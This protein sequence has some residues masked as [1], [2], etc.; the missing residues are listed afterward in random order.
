LHAILL[1]AGDE[2]LRYDI[3]RMI[4]SAPSRDDRDALIEALNDRNPHVAR[5]AARA[6]VR[7][8]DR[9]VA[10]ILRSKALDATDRK[11]AEEFN[12]AA[13]RLGG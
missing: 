8:G 3:V 2:N 7:V 9:S 12:V 10:P 11:V 13:S 1:E 5:H 4:E 6:L